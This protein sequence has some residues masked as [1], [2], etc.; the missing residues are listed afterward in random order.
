MSCFPGA[1]PALHLA[2]RINGPDPTGRETVLRPPKASRPY[3]HPNKHP[4]RRVGFAEGPKE[5]SPGFTPCL[6]PHRCKPLRPSMLQGNVR[7][8]IHNVTGWK[9]A[10]SEN[11]LP[12]VGNNKGFTLGRRFPPDPA[13]KGRQKALP[14]GSTTPS[15]LDRDFTVTQGKPSARFL[16][17]FRPSN[18]PPAG[19]A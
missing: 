8:N 18:R 14:T 6:Y 3:A 13:L 10:A 4:P 17:P 7:P 12:D 19:W 1:R 5:L 9:A 16:W 2:E 11:E 15:G